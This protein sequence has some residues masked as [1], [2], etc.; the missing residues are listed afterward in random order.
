MSVGLGVP[1]VVEVVDKLLPLFVA[2][3]DQIEGDVLAKQR[4]AVEGCAVLFGEVLFRGVVDGHQIDF[5]LFQ[6][7]DALVEAVGGSD[8]QPLIVDDPLDG[9]GEPPLGHA[10]GFLLPGRGFQPLL[11][12]RGVPGLDIEGDGGAEQ[13]AVAALVGPGKGERGDGVAQ[14]DVFKSAWP[15]LVGDLQIRVASRF[16]NGEHLACQFAAIGQ[17]R[18]G[19]R[20]QFAGDDDR[21]LRRAGREQR[22]R[23]ERGK[24]RMAQAQTRGVSDREGEWITN[25]HG[26]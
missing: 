18:R 26:W 1:F 3:G 10:G 2:G 20:G 14:L 24:Q 17:L 23:K 6:Q 19:V 11:V 9:V 5:A 8:D 13:Q 4:E 15:G 16:E 25:V 12:G 22:E 7:L 21:T